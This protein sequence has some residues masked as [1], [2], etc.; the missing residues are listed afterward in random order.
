MHTQTSPHNVPLSFPSYSL[1]RERR[2]YALSIWFREE[3]ECG[4]G[5]A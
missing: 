5:H 3:W 2:L 1:E 4:V